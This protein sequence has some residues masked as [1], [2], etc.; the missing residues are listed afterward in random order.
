MSVLTVEN[1]EKDRETFPLFPPFFYYYAVETVEKGVR[2]SHRS[3]R[4]T[5]YTVSRF[6]VVWERYNNKKYS[7]FCPLGV[8]RGGRE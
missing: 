6:A 4:A 8:T 3:H 5:A 2:L 7:F 1:V